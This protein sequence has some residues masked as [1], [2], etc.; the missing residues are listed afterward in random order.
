MIWSMPCG[1]YTVYAIE[2]G[3]FFREPSEMFP[4]SDPDV[5]DA[6][7]EWLTDGQLRISL[8]CF[9]VVGGRSP[10]LID[11]G[12]GG[13]PGLPPGTESGHL[14]E[15]LAMLAVSP[16]DIETVIHTHLHLDHCG[17]DRTLSGAP[18][19]P[20]ARF[21]LQEAEVDYWLGAEGP[22][23]DAVREVML[24]F[25]TDD[26]IEAVAGERE[27][28]PG[29]IVEPTPG[30]TPGH[31]SVTIAS[32]GTRTFITGD[33]THHP[34]QVPD[35]SWG[36]PFD[37]DPGR[38]RTTRERVFERLSG[39]GTVMAAG[40]Y[41]RPGM[42]YVEVDDGVRVFIRGTALQEA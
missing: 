6:H 13:R 36:V 39:S 32:L 30:H 16:A 14:P 22:G 19:F 42:G 2:D 11:A 18:F 24:G 33:V 5:W 21:V 25:V 3:W 26:R 23:A 40:H 20:N 12:A 31:Q 7:P 4:E 34:A 41:P 28:L 37:V 10:V 17:G 1:A 38:A 9:L 8:G 27:V 15:A 29:I 35:P